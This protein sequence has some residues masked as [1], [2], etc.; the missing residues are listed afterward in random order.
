MNHRYE[1]TY[2]KNPYVFGSIKSPLPPQNFHH[3]N[4]NSPILK[5]N[6][7]YNQPN[8]NYNSI[9]TFDKNP[10]LLLNSATQLQNNTSEVSFARNF[11]HRLF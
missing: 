9:S 5:D 1:E 4:T 3:N 10:S 8:P 7:L 6:F 2:L 11:K